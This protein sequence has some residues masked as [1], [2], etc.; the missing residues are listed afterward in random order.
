MKHGSLFG[1]IHMRT[2]FVQ[3]DKRSS[4]RWT[5]GMSRITVVGD[6]GPLHSLPTV[7][8]RKSCLHCGYCTQS[9]RKQCPRVWGGHWLPTH[10]RYDASVSP[11]G[12]LLPEGVGSPAHQRWSLWTGPAVDAPYFV[13]SPRDF[14][15]DGQHESARCYGCERSRSNKRWAEV[16]AHAG[17]ERKKDSWQN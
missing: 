5:M 9:S 3:I 8:L 12:I 4:R 14:P 13:F 1:S 15:A 11:N 17:G 2:E 16:A 10:D 6:Y 7:F